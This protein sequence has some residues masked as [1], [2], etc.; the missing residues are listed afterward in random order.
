MGK[1]GLYPAVSKNLY[2]SDVK[3]LMDL[4][5]YSDGKRSLIEIADLLGVPVWDL[6]PPIMILSK[7]NLV[8]LLAEKLE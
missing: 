3:I 8:N 4:I 1:R 2:T 5:S 7:K 6:Y